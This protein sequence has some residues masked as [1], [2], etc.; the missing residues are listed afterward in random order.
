[1]LILFVLFICGIVFEK[2]VIIKYKIVSNI[3]N[4]VFQLIFS[5]FFALMVYM[6][7]TWHQD[8]MISISGDASDIWK[9]ITSFHTKDIYGSYVLYKGINVNGR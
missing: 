6:I 5:F 4:R 1:M 7:F 8:S 9:T 2:F 3:F